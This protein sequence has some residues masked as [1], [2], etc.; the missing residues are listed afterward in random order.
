MAILRSGTGAIAAQERYVISSLGGVG[1]SI[2]TEQAEP[3]PIVVPGADNLGDAVLGIQGGY[4]RQAV[5]DASVVITIPDLGKLPTFLD[6]TAITATLRGSSGVPVS[7]ILR[8]QAAVR[9]Q[10]RDIPVPRFAIQRTNWNDVGDDDAG[11][12]GVTRFF[13]R[14]IDT[15]TGSSASVIT[16]RK[17]TRLNSSHL[18]LSRMPSSA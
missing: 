14:L 8:N 7:Q 5:N 17:S 4:R 3:V 16:D 10:S 9:G 2:V 6:A 15:T 12:V 13:N 18:K 1:P 11:A